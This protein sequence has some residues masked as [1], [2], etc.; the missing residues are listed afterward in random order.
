[1]VV[2]VLWQNPKPE[3]SR[4]GGQLYRFFTGEYRSPGPRN[5]A[6][7]G[8]KFL[9][10]Q[11]LTRDHLYRTKSSRATNRV[12]SVSCRYCLNPVTV[13]S[14][15]GIEF[16]PPF[17]RRSWKIGCAFKSLTYRHPQPKK[18]ATTIFTRNRH[19]FTSRKTWGTQ[20]GALANLIQ[21]AWENL[22]GHYPD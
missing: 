4:L 22:G 5:L 15:I 12:Y 7:G 10:L 18:E 20:P 13:G 21:A 2:Q 16:E 9:A 17:L 3:Y 14:V 8:A 19:A 6:S 11:P 1:M